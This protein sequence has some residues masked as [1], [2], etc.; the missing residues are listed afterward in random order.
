MIAGLYILDE[1]ACSRAMPSLFFY[2]EANL[3]QP[4]CYE[5]CGVAAAAEIACKDANTCSVCEDVNFG[6]DCYSNTQE[7]CAEIDCCS[8]CEAEIRAMWACEHGTICGDELSCSVAAHELPMICR[9]D[10]DQDGIVDINDL[11][12]VLGAFNIFMDA[13][14]CRY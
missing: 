8:A 2:G 6:D 10:Q 7:H 4:A 9:A 11:L 13:S 3:F 1:K 14:Y 12:G 5:S